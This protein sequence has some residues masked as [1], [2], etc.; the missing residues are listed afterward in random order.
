MHLV[1]SL[2]GAGGAVGATRL[3]ELAAALE[4]SLAQ[5]LPLSRLARE[6]ALLQVELRHLVANIEEALP[7]A[8]TRPLE[9][10]DM[11]IAKSELD[12]FEKLIASADFSAAAMYRAL[13]PRLRERFGE[14]ARQL[15]DALRNF[16][17]ERALAL[18]RL[19]R[20]R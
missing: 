15:G 6:S 17:H 19:L 14:P 3:V 5:P 20:R 12:D 2:R 11:E 4:I 1:H 13:A 7:G 9:L 18:L 8:E 16:D 10:D